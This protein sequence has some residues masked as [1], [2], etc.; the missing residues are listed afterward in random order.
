METKI[1]LPV[2]HIAAIGLLTA[3]IAALQT[4]PVDAAFGI[5]SVS[6]A[7]ELPGPPPPNLFEGSNEQPVDT[8]IT[9]FGLPIVFPEV[10]GGYILPTAGYPGG[11][12][13]M[14]VDHN[15]TPVNVS[16]VVDGTNVNVALQPSVLPVGTHFNSYMLHY[17]PVDQFN[18]GVDP[19]YAQY[20][21]EVSFDR[22]I[23][24]VQIFSKYFPLEYAALP[25]RGK[26]EDGDLQISLN[27][28]PGPPPTYYPDPADFRGLE[29]DSFSLV[30]VGNTVKIGGTA[31]G[32]E[33]DEVRIF[34]AAVPE[35]AAAATWAIIL[36]LGCSGA[37]VWRRFQT[38][39]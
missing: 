33:I 20:I 19:F 11:L 32:P 1:M 25:Y 28:G 36:A 22:P 9:F 12:L 15:G 31:N 4:Q 37:F 16:P 38:N 35:P 10:L 3:A 39:I 14:G 30:I 23:I 13:G 24:G 6:G 34:T 2:R 17:D 7:T 8:A 21:S 26:L 29:E 27:G 5:V 18:P